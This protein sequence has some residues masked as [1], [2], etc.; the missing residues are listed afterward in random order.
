[1]SPDLLEKIATAV[2]GG[3]LFTGLAALAGKAAELR[4]EKAK[5]KI[6]LSSDGRTDREMVI[7]RLEKQR[8]HAEEREGAALARIKELEAEREAD[9]DSYREKIE[10]MDKKSHESARL[11]RARSLRI[12]ELKLALRRFQQDHPDAIDKDGD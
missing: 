1:V 2:L 4:G 11:A 8:D 5:H 6:A 12:L 10:R 7:D 3:G 9:Y